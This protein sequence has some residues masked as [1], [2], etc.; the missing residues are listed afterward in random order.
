MSAPP[1]PAALHPA[2][3]ADEANFAELLAQYED[4]N[5]SA[6]P[7][8]GERRT[9][10][11]VNVRDNV[12]LV[13]VGA[14]AEGL[15]PLELWRE[16]GPAGAPAEPAAGD[17]IEVV[18]EGRDAD[19]SLKLS[20]F[21]PDRPR[22]LEDARAAFEQGIVVRGKV[23]GVIKGGLTVDVGMRAFI[24]QSKTGAPD[25][26]ALHKLVG[27]QV[28]CRI[29]R[30]PEKGRLVLDR[31]SLLEEEQRACEQALLEQLREGDVISG[32]VR[33][34][35]LY[36]AFVDI[37]GLDALLHVSDISWTRLA[38]PARMLSL[39]DEL[40]VKV[41]KVDPQRRRVSVGL[42][43]LTPDPWEHVLATYRTGDRV[44]GAVQRLADFGAFVELEPG[45]EGLIHISEMSWARRVR[46]AGDVVNV[47]DVVEAIVL[48][49]NPAERRISLG[50]KQALGDP[51]QDAETRFK[52]GTI[53]E[54]R[55]RNLQPFG[56]FIEIAEGVDGM[57][58]IG[59][60]APERLQHP[61][62]VVK[63]GDTVRAQVLELNL[64]KRQ[65]RL[66]MKQLAPTP[67]DEFVKDH[68][69]G[70]VLTARVVRAYP[71]RVALADGV[72]AACP[73]A[74]PAERKIEEGTLAAKLRAVWKPPT[75]PPDEVPPPPKVQ[76][77]VGEVR[78]F[79]ILKIEKA[80]NKELIEVEPA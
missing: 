31:R 33:S 37:G 11:V 48:G 6:G 53:V 29:A 43:Q 18:I 68:Q 42:K 15:L 57:V 12:A 76:L 8:A 10:R 65:L 56:A 9:G 45:V 49:V 28:R 4:R 52:P 72:E 50:L 46:K 7:S 1:D 24:P 77:K 19:G 36:G 51:W 60:L 38:E 3:A 61:S 27:Q 80:E 20:P 58:H 22:T 63:V 14:K 62:Q 35:A 26:N 13:D 55:V 73:S 30:M 16:I 67:F 41:L 79:R 44:K 71:G 66:G 39:G 78:K 70:E 75:P 25:T 64:A 21:A 5:E 17:T 74:A 34:L 23:T 59:D 54:G 32:R 2:P 47:G 40:Q 69:V